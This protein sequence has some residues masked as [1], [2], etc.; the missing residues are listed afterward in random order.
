MF[1]VGHDGH[2]FVLDITAITSLDN[3]IFTKCDWQVFNIPVTISYCYLPFNAYKQ[4]YDILLF[5]EVHF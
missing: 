3:K 1:F 2:F 4:Y 5:G